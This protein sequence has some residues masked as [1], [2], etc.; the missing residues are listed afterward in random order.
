MRTVRAAFSA[1]RGLI[2]QHDTTTTTRSIGARARFTAGPRLFGGERAPR[3][4]LQPACSNPRAPTPI[5]HSRSNSRA[6]GAGRAPVDAY[7][8]RPMPSMKEYQAKV[9]FLRARF[10]Q[11]K[12]SL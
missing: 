2:Q 6:L 11:L 7:N 10:E 3:S 9:E 1:G 12:E 8:P 5:A 4:V